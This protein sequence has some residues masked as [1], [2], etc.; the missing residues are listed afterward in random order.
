MAKA[1][2][3]NKKA[4]NDGI[5]RCLFGGYSVAA[6]NRDIGYYG[7]DHCADCHQYVNEAVAR[8][9]AREMAEVTLNDKL[10]AYFKAR[11]GQ[12]L[13]GR[14]LSQVA[15]AYAWRSRCSDLRRLF[16]MDIQNKQQRL[17]NAEGKPYTVSFY[18][19][20]PAEELVAV[21]VNAEGQSSFL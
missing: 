7:P 10:A 20:V 15:G 4:V 8:E 12:W 5:P 14:V 18:R 11:P 2:S 16:S 3:G 9:D 6:D 19:Y 17:K 1:D 13:D 21:S